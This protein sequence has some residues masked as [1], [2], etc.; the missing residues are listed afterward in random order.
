MHLR[1]LPSSLQGL[2]AQTL[3]L[4]PRHGAA[5]AA[6]IQMSPTRWDPETG[7]RV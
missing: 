1:T 4:K 3:N 5:K 7:S 2:R 6:E